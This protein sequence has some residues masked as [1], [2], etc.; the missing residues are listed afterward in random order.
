M[1]DSIRDCGSV[2]GSAPAFVDNS[3]LARR[4]GAVTHVCRAL[5]GI[6]AATDA[7]THG[8]RA[9]R[10]IRV[11]RGLRTGRVT[12]YR[13][14]RDGRNGRGTASTAAERHRRPRN[15]RDGRGMAAPPTGP[16]PRR[17]PRGAALPATAGPARR[18]N[19]AAPPPPSCTARHRIP[20]AARVRPAIRPNPETWRTPR[21][22]GPRGPATTADPTTEPNRRPRGDQPSTGENRCS[23]T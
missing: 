11:N 19:T 12:S 15:G 4:S 6:G 8:H 16:P 14:P 21:R 1:Q 2:G 3:S 13:R 20:P 18:R 17:P 23:I 22:T 10:G 5:R 9:L 7:P